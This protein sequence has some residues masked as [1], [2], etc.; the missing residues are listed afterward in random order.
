MGKKLPGK[1]LATFET[2]PDI[3]QE[4][5]NSHPGLTESALFRER[6]IKRQAQ[7]AF[8]LDLPERDFEGSEPFLRRRMGLGQR[9]SRFALSGLNSCQPFPHPL[10]GREVIPSPCHEIGPHIIGL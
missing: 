3:W 8:G 7:S 9:C 5:L 2:T 6:E 10:N 1:G 4:V